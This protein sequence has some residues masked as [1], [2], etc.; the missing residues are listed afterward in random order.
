MSHWG[1][2]RDGT[3]LVSIPEGGFLAG[4]NKVNV[5]LPAYYLARHPV[6]NEQ[7]QRFVKE[8]GHQWCNRQRSD[9]EDWT[10]RAGPD[11]PAVNVSWEDAQAYCKWAGLRLP[12]ELEWEKGARGTDGRQYPWGNEWDP[13]KCR[14]YENHGKEE[15]SKVLGYAEGVSPW[16]MY[17]MSGN[18][19]EWCED[20]YDSDSRF[21]HVVRGG[22]WNASFIRDCYL[23]AFR[24]P[25]ASCWTTG[26]TTSGSG[27]LRH[28]SN[29]KKESSEV[30][31]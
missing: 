23:C 26:T 7:Y 28:N 8:T 5:V 25:S 11:H 14:N 29:G 19:W 2:W 18:V 1:E 15:T 12:S 4:D 13:S 31:C 22:S 6:T 16:G 20:C 27:V 3:Q 30:S 17:Q 10:A 9:Q 21:S 24:P